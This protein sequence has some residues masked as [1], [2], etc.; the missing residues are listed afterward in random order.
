MP[1]VRE[2]GR[3]AAGVA[4]PQARLGRPKETVEVQEDL[5]D[6]PP[7]ELSLSD[8]VQRARLPL[9]EPANSQG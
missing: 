9:A 1:R 7:E 4:D 6:R 2:A 8:L 3:L 5:R